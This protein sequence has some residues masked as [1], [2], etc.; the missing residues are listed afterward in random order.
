MLGIEHGSPAEGEHAVVGGQ[1]L[2]DGGT[3]QGAEDGLAVVDEDLGDLAPGGGLDVVVGVAHG[4]AQALGHQRADSRL[5]GAHR[6]D[7]HD[8][9]EL[10]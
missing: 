4:R 5:A 1:G 8:H 10:T 6:P 7:H 3:L 2:S 9:R